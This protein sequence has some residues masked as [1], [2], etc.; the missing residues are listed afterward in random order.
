M[1]KILPLVFGT[2]SMFS[3]S[4]QYVVTSMEGV[5][6]PVKIS[7]GT[8][9]NTAEADLVA[10]Y[11]GLLDSQMNQIIAVSSEYMTY[12]RPESLL[13]NLTS[14]VMLEFGKEYTNGNCDLASMNVNG[15][16]ANLSKG[17]VTLGNMFEVYSFENALVIIKLKGSDLSDIFRSYAK[18]NG[19]GI[20]GNANLSIKDGELIS[21]TIDG[22]PVDND[23]IYTI[24]T[25]DYLADGNDSMDAFAKSIERIETGITLRS[26]MMD[27]F[28]EQ[29]AQGKQ[30]SST[31][32]G[33]I[34]VEQ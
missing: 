12:G 5:R 16:R 34:K 31:L 27:Y 17:N 18:I 3:C 28:K 11:K 14:D 6:I 29:A 30:I 26:A 2:I 8:K 20:S 7:Q 10:E 1:R 9:V 25:L 13:T 33:R 21:A 24:I 4:T 22:K 32:D 23:K 19:S 15:H